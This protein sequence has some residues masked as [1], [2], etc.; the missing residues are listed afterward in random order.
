VALEAA[1]GLAYWQGDQ[2]T[3]QRIYDESLEITRRVGDKRAIANAIYNVGFPMM[4]RRVQLDRARAL[5][6]EAL[7]LFEELHDQV[8]V[9]RSYWGL[10]NADY[11][12][13]IYEPARQSLETAEAI[14]R[15]LDDRFDL[16]WSVHTL[17]LVAF[18]TGRVDAA[19]AYFSEA[20]TL[21]VQAQDV[22]GMVLQLDNLSAVARLEGDPIGATRLA[23]AAAAHQLTT[24]TGLGGLLSSEEGRNGREGLSEA[25]AEAAWA[26]GQ[27]MN[28]EQAVAYALG[29]RVTEAPTTHG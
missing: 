7:A 18:K 25:A 29:G 1:G 15:R 3:A 22:S 14:F 21:F 19:R 11:F 5:F 2:D 13:Q 20:L 23:A 12:Q 28:L 6:R 4:V 24:G 8:G 17:G 27:S 9:G 16:A 10:G 26:E